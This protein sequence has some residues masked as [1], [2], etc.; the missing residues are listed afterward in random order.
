MLDDELK[1][2]EHYYEKDFPNMNSYLRK[3][4]AIKNFLSNKAFAASKNTNR[5]LNEIDF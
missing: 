5:K 1:K 2:R 3:I 4:S